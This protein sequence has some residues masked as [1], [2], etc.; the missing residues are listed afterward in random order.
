MDTREQ[1]RKLTLRQQAMD[2]RRRKMVN[3][4][5]RGVTPSAAAAEDDGDN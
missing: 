4:E 5:S 2:D 3:C 1:I